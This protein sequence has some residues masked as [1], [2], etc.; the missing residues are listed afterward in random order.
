[1]R[2]TIFGLLL[3][4]LLSLTLAAPAGA[5]DT[6]MSHTCD[7]TLIALL[8]VAEHDYGF[9]SMQDLSSFEKGQFQPLFDAMMAMGSMDDDM[10][11]SD[12]MGGDSMGGDMMDGVTLLPGHIADEDPACTALR[13]ELDKFMTDT[14]L[15]SLEMMGESTGSTDMMAPAVA[16]AP[17]QTLPVVDARTGATFTLGD[18][19]GKTVFVEPMATWCTNCRAQLNNVAA[20][21]TQAMNDEVVYIALSVETDLSAQ[22]L[23]DY[24][25]AN[26]FDWM[27]AV[28]TPEL[29]SALVTTFGFSVTTPP[30]T[31]HFVIRP[32]N[33]VTPLA[34]GMKS[35]EAVLALVSG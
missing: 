35:P 22:A 29:L 10:S 5:Q 17:W 27:F 33:S 31:P 18:F 32:D 3:A 4:A 14:L 30:S 24:A 12:M 9:Q 8:Y 15:H 7:S 34:T 1:M 21:R 20:A 25:N 2:K 28:A 16:L 11:E 26:G 19:A 6:M 23:A 13:E